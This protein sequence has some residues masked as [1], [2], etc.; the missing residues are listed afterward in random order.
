M[1]AKVADADPNYFWKYTHF[2]SGMV[3]LQAVLVVGDFVVGVV[4]TAFRSLTFLLRACSH[5]AQLSRARNMPIRTVTES[6]LHMRCLEKV[7]HK[8]CTDER[9]TDRTKNP[10]INETNER[11]ETL[12]GPTS[13]FMKT[14]WAYCCH[15]C[16]SAALSL[17]MFGDYVMSEGE[18]WTDLPH[19]LKYVTALSCEI[20]KLNCASKPVY[21]RKKINWQLQIYL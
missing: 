20:C 16:Q 14:F 17:T 3:L 4:C 11:Y 21:R 5:S 19:R 6:V 18:N 13:L 9:R 8:K 2:T 10:A 7:S 12:Y 15:R 1:L